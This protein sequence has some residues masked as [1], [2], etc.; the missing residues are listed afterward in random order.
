MKPAAIIVEP[1]QGEGG[2]IPAPAFWL[3]ELRRICDEHGILLIFDE[4]QCGVGKTGHNFAFEE[5]GIIPDV[6]CLSKAIGGGLP[7]SILVINKNTTH[8][9]RASTP[10]PSV[11]TSLQWYLALK[12]LKSFSVITSLSMRVLRVNTYALA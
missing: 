9:V 12:R 11:A 3:R 10:E 6:L 5:S 1:V 8:G 4:I 2:V 7:M